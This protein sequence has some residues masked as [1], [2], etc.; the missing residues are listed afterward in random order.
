MAKYEMV[1]GIEEEY[2]SLTST[3]PSFIP[4]GIEV[5]INLPTDGWTTTEEDRVFKWDCRTFLAEVFRDTF[6]LQSAFI[7][8]NQ[9]NTANLNAVGVAI[10]NAQIYDINNIS[11]DRLMLTTAAY[12]NSEVRYLNARSFRQIVVEKA[13]LGRA[14]VSW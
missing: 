11:P 3:T 5:G 7:Q 8:N 1:L 4:T 9:E 13:L 12:I 6:Y 2:G 10:R 14:E